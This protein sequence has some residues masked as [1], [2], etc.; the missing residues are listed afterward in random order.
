[1][2]DSLSSKKAWEDGII[3][4]YGS[5]EAYREAAKEWRSRGGQHKGERTFAKDPD[6]ASTAGKKGYQSMRAKLKEE[7]QKELEDELN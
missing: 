7:L 3:R 2:M 5:L 4:R 6:L 1:M